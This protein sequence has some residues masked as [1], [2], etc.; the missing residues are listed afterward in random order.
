[1]YKLLGE[2]RR[3]PI[4]RCVSTILTRLY[5]NAYNA[6]K[7]YEACYGDQTII[8]ISEVVLLQLLQFWT[9]LVSRADS[10]DRFSSYVL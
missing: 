3:L 8:R 4:I 9:A 6:D 5:Q 10:E 1:M 7:W 2:G